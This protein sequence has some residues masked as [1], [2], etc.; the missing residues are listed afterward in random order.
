MSNDRFPLGRILVTPGLLDACSSLQMMVCLQRHRIGDWG[1]LDEHDRS[2]N[3]AALR[4]GNRLL[5][6][7]FIDPAKPH[8]DAGNQF[9]IVTEHDR[10][11]TTM[12]LPSEY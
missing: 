7:Y 10:S 6:V 5:S 1:I 12:L 11:T 3:D 2:L 8:D 4:V 9:W